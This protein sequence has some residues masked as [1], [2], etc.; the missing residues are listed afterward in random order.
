M[1]AMVDR[2][3]IIGITAGDPAG[4][5]PEVVIKTLLDPMIRDVCWPVV[6]GDRANLQW[7]IDKLGL[8]AKLETFGTD[9]TAEIAVIDQA[10][11]NESIEF[12][13]ESS[14][15]GRS[16]ALNIESAVELWKSGRIDAI[17]TAPISKN[18][19]KLAGVSHPGHTEFL[20]ALTNTKEFAMSFFAEKLRVVLLS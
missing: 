1:S 2:K 9:D 8:D 4:I 20:A 12:G 16:A 19:L 11:I 17:S 7:T 3:P 10:N 18:A 15:T 14:A 13:V 6:I 5:G